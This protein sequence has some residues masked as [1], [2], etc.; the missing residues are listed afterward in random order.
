MT[1]LAVLDSSVAIDLHR[2]G[3]LDALFKLPA[4]YMVPDVMFADELEGWFGEALI[5]HGL[6]I[7][8]L[9]HSEVAD[10]REFLRRCSSLSLSDAYALAL[11]VRGKHTILAGA[12]DIRE[13]GTEAGIEVRG[14]LAC[15]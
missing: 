11:A 2:G 13:L 12:R 6:I 7:R 14:V 5:S 1:P 3:L 9:D 4:Q 8:T 10:A 15:F